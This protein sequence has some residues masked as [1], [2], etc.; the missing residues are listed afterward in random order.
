MMEQ[1]PHTDRSTLEIAP[2]EPALPLLRVA[3]ET[4]AAERVLAESDVLAVI[5]FGS[6]APASADS[7]Y[8]SVGLEPICS[9]PP[10]EVWRS[11]GPVDRGRTE[12]GMSGTIRWASDG[13]YSFAAIEVDEAA[14]DGIAGAARAAYAALAAW[15]NANPVRHVLRI[16][17]YLDAINVGDGDDE[18]YRLFCAGRAA[19]MNGMFAAGYPAATAIGTRNGRRTLQMYW[20]AARLA[21]V[22]LENP[23]QLSAWRYPR[24]H[25]PS[26]PN[27]ARAMRAP[28]RSPQLYIS[29][30]AAI[31]GH[32]SHH[33]GDSAAQLNETLS[34][35]DSLLA[36]ARI[37]GS[38]SFGPR[39]NWKIY[40]RHAQDAPLA[41]ALLAK[42]L[43]ANASL[44]LLQGDVCRA[45][46]LVEIDG[47]QNS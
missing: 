42:R 47:I 33:A 13:D 4:V 19:G 17:N 36:S 7:R 21:G 18:R 39:G 45:E 14:H 28:T 37:D 26:A 1:S 24:C 43:G 46:L 23:R 9:P 29:G 2:A 41:Q 40:L 32:L 25:G 15:C 16:W 3:Y 11:R 27:F 44:L 5:A 10:L 35:L 12:C 38:A 30:T 6:T 20:L 34:N 8:L 31:I 22:P